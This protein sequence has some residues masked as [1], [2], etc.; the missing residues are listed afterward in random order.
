MLLEGVRGQ[1]HVAQSEES[2]EVSPGSRALIDSGNV[3][4]VVEIRVGHDEVI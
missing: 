2:C 3:I 1:F 4:R